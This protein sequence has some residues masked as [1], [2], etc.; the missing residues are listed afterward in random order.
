MLLVASET[1]HVY[2]FATSKLQPMITS[3]NGKELIQTCLNS[4]DSP[5]SEHETTA[6]VPSA[7][8]GAA[9]V[10]SSTETSDMGTVKSTAGNHV[11]SVP[12]LLPLSD[13][14]VRLQAQQ[15]MTAVWK[16]RPQRCLKCASVN[17]FYLSTY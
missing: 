6:L 13:H 7:A 17:L 8:V 15:V 4:P 12:Q 10:S 9:T 3:E 14:G 5:V 11:F 16:F 1:G 2:T